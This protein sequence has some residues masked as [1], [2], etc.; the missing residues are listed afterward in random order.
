MTD[1]PSLVQYKNFD[2]FT[3]INQMFDDIKRKNQNL[4]DVFN[5][6]SNNISGTAAMQI[7]NSTTIDVD[8]INHFNKL[9][10]L[11]PDFPPL[12]NSVVG[13]VKLDLIYEFKIN[14]HKDSYYQLQKEIKNKCKNISDKTFDTF[15]DLV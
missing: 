2:E 6:Y 15:L 11:F 1:P 10:K 7:I 13:V 4:I 3:H 8:S 14:F 9:F 5:T 12:E